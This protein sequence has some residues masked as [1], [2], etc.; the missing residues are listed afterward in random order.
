[1]MLRY[2]LNEEALANMVEQAVQKVIHA[3][4]RTSDLTDSNQ[5]A[6]GTQEMGDAV[7]DALSKLTD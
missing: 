4:Y 7:V 5:Q 2:S 1:M 3:G 6:L